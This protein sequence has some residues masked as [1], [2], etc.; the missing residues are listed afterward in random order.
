MKTP[1]ETLDDASIKLPLS[2]VIIAKN[3]ERHVSRCL[4]SVKDIASEIIV[5]H[6]D[7]TD[8]TVKIAE[9]FGAKTVEQEWLGFRDQKNVA[10]DHATQ[11]WI[12]SLDSDEELS[13]DLSQSIVQFIEKDD[14]LFNGAYFPRKVWF[15][16]RWITHGTWYPDY[17][18]RLLRQGRGRWTGEV[19]HEK[20]EVDG[21]VKK[22][23]A[24]L[25][26]FPFQDMKDQLT[27]MV[28]YSDL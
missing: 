12:L 28:G 16:G 14:P 17:S 22:L 19:I 2:V 6:N 13:S 11:P 1:V 24:D 5:V 26:H 15:M 9:E 21:A 20:L 10:L 23:N 25:L 4:G 18:L 27:K 7:C 8:D 3:A